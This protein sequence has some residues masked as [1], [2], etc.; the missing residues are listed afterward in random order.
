[1]SNDALLSSK[2]LGYT[3]AYLTSKSATKK[4]ECILTCTRYLTI[5]NIMK[6][7]QKRISF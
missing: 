6:P 5:R 7:L 2:L 4:V 1:M 3:C